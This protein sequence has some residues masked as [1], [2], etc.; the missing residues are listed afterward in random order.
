MASTAAR[1]NVSSQ[2]DGRMTARAL[3]IAWAQAAGSSCPASRTEGRVAAHSVT[4][5]SSG[6]DPAI[7]RLSP[8]VRP[9]PPRLAAMAR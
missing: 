4:A 6:P 1:P 2:A 5:G 3:A 7:S 9:A 8:G